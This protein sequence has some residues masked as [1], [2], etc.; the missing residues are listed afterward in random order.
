MPV[1][2]ACPPR[3]II[4]PAKRR[5]T[6]SAGGGWGG[7]KTRDALTPPHCP[8][9]QRLTIIRS[10]A[11]FYNSESEVLRKALPPPPEAVTS[12]CFHPQKHAG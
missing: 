11:K 4:C 8:A 10:E 5:R 7:Q 6:L 12:T 3:L 2:S 1:P 9:S